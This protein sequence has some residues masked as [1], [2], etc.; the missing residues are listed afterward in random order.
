MQATRHLVQSSTTVSGNGT[1]A[2]TV[3]TRASKTFE[4]WVNVTTAG[5]TINFNLQTSE[6]GTNFKTQKTITVT[7]TGADCIVIN[8]ADYAM[9][10]AGRLTWDTVTGSFTF[11]SYARTYE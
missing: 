8:R 3:S 11:E 9:G 10:A 6:D 2:A 1:S 4:V 7:G 5:T